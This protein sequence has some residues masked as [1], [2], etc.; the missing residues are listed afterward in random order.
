MRAFTKLSRTS[1][2]FLVSDTGSYVEMEGLVLCFPLFTSFQQI[3]RNS[4]PLFI[5]IKILLN[6]FS[7]GVSL[8]SSTGLM[9][10]VLAQFA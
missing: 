10:I 5:I 9:Q 3:T 2:C 1:Q 8:R 6:Q 7:A 4:E